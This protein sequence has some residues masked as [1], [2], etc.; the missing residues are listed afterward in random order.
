MFR[1]W[2]ECH[3][4]ALESDMGLLKND[5]H[6]YYRQYLKLTHL[7]KDVATVSNWTNVGFVIKFDEKTVKDKHNQI[8]T[9]TTL[10][11]IKLQTFNPLACF[12]VLWTLLSLCLSLYFLPQMQAFFETDDTE[13][14]DT[15]SHGSFQSLYLF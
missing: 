7:I 4:E 13:H 6:Y 10:E 11:N 14:N 8:F 12:G 5:L 2:F 3:R 15:E 9:A 1:F